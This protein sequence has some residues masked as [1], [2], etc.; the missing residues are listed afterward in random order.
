MASPEKIREAVN[1]IRSTASANYQNQVPALA[2]TDTID[3]IGFVLQSQD[4]LTEFTNG[5]VNRI[6][7]TMVE[8][9]SFKNPLAI[10]KKGANRL[11]SDIQHMYTNPAKSKEY[12]LSEAEMAKLLSYNESDDKIV[13]YRRNRRDLYEVSVPEDE[14]NAAFVS[15]EALGDLIENKVR[16]LTNGNTI[17]EFYYTKNMLSK[18]VT[19]ATIQMVEVSNP[20][21]EA[22]AKAFVK[23]VKKLHGKFLFPSTKYNS[24]Q[25]LFPNDTPVMTNSEEGS[26]CLI[27]GV[28]P[29]AEIDV[30][31]L[32]DAFNMQ[33]AE[34][35]SRIVKIDEFSNENLVGIICDESFLQLYDNLF[36]F[37][38]FYN[39][40]ALVYNYY[41]H[42]W[43]TFALSPFAN[44]V[45]LVTSTATV[46]PTGV[47]VKT[48]ELNLKVGDNFGIQAKVTPENATDKG[49]NFESSDDTVAYVNSKGYITALK[50]GTATI[51]VSSN[52]EDEHATTV[53]I[54]VSVS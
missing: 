12:N 7:K 19:N 52:S 37:R 9:K 17:D 45:A 28:D 8:K 48:T 26:I 32:A 38:N 22:T 10:F 46:D 42:A 13:Y 4:L 15:L 41:V 6:I 47:E 1:Y 29:L 36:K 24:Y 53:E 2:S 49:I 54:A 5:L 23:T 30:E 39:G 35:S 34:I 40:R 16:S 33:K 20:V 14:L 11:G 25:R 31:L 18:A 21:D 27:V 50:A 43:G 44:A 51:T 3:K